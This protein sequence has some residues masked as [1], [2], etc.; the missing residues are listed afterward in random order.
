MM[1]IL[2]RT[3]L[4]A[5]LACFACVC[6]LPA[7]A[8]G[9]LE[10][11]DAWIRAAPPGAMML[12][13]YA[14]LRNVGDAPVVIVGAS[15]DAFGSVSLHESVSEN[16][17]ERMRPLGRITIAP[18]AGVALRPGGK[19]LMLMQPKGAMTPGAS[20]PIRFETGGGTMADATFVVRESAP[21]GG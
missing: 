16:G 12:A 4:A 1:T 15:S 17:V 3:L 2:K 11:R 5:C 7:Q 20:A 21:D 14:Q 13:G 9:R 8:A 10:V 19:H 18:G 6:S